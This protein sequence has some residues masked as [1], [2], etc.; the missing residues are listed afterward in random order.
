MATITFKGKVQDMLY[1]GETVPSY[2]YIKIPTLDRKH[3]DMS[4]FRNHP[5]YGGLANSDLFNSCLARIKRDIFG[6]SDLL[7][8][9]NIP[10]NVTVDMSGFL[11]IVTI[12]V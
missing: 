5:R 1:S 6:T 2:Q 4:A 9:N 7:K 11:A 10:A 8:L 12:E 3:C